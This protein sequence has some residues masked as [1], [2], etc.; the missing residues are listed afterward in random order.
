MCSMCYYRLCTISDTRIQSEID[1]RNE[2]IR[3]LTD[4]YTSEC[5]IRNKM[6]TERNQL[7]IE[8][9]ITVY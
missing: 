3:E 7:T 5:D 8:L 2:N 6:E 1:K 9:V 4:K